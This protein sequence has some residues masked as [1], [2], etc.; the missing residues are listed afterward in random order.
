MTTAASTTVEGLSAYFERAAK[1][2]PA[3]PLQRLSIFLQDWRRLSPRPSEAPVRTPLSIESLRTGLRAL[4]PLHQAARRSAA[5]LNIWAVAGLGHDEVR[6][7]SV[8]AW[9]LNPA[10][11][12]GAGDLFAQAL[13]RAVDG[14]KFG[15]ELTGLRRSATE[16]CPLA[17]TADRVDVVLEGDDFVVFI[18]VKIHAG[19]QPRQLERYALAAERSA[20]LR[21]KAHCAVIY[22]APNTAILPDGCGWLSWRHLA[23]A[24]RSSS[25]PVESPF[26]TQ[27]AIQFAGHIECF[28]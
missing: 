13:W 19:L 22:L 21:G 24:L 7:S 11:S 6:T 14:P 28:G 3:T 10:A 12:H 4:A 2:A 26:V 1:A 23:R 17:D 9:L 5:G 18:E 25:A 15:F 8:L 20:R 27:A 16:V